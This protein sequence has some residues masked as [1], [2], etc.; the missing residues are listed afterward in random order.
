MKK[1]YTLS[2]FLLAAL[3]AN[4]QS[5]SQSLTSSGIFVVPSGVT[6]LTVELVGAGGAGG[7]NGG[8]GG[9][10]GGYASGIYT[11]T[12]GDTIYVDVGT[13]GGG[14]NGGATNIAQLGITAYGGDNGTSVANPNLGG[15]GVGGNA[16]G[17][18]LL[19]NTGGNGGGG[20]WTYF[21]GGGGGAAGPIG[22][23][24]T[25]GNTI[26][27]TG[28]CMTPGGSGGPG[29]GAP[30]GDGGKGAGFTDANCNVTDPAGNGTNYGAGGGG[31]N[32]NG[33]NAGTGAGGY[34]LF[35]WGPTNVTAA[36]AL[37]AITVAPNPFT[38]KIQVQHAKGNEFYEL[39]DITG[40]IVWSGNTIQQADFSALPPAVY[41]LRISGAETVQTK[42][43]VKQ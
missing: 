6:V 18:N 31:G 30:G 16:N 42:R 25:G 4:A 26:P 20:Y 19:N 35:T 15:G 38:D 39:M 21:G 37:N 41:L 23:G 27:W 10:G 17:G 1:I 43:V 24:T 11:V 36:A 2:A 9:G 34:C 28:V 5:G 32:G 12:P 3:I 29:G 40:Q 14:P 13:A 8:G 33:G 22:N 7:G